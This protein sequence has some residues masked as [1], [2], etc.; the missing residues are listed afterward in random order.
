[1]NA[2]AIST[3][4]A[5]A[6]GVSPQLFLKS[7]STRDSRRIAGCLRQGNEEPRP[8]YAD[9]TRPSCLPNH[10]SPAK[11]QVLRTKKPRS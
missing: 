5:L 7:F 10:R 11:G 9:Q 6:G 1:M 4:T 8:G 3:G 2:D